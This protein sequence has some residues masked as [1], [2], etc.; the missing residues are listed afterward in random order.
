LRGAAEI[1]QLDPFLVRSDG[2]SQPRGAGHPRISAGRQPRAGQH[3]ISHS[4]Y[5]GI[6]VLIAIFA[7]I[8][9]LAPSARWFLAVLGGLNFGWYVDELG[10][11]E[12]AGCLS[13]RRSRSST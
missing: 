12:H 5:G 3:P 11:Y 8:S 4:I 10:K 1:G 2:Q 13:S 6:A 9:F 7:A